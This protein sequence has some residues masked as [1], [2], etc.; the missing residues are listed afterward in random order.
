MRG[1]GGADACDLGYLVTVATDACVTQSAERQDWS[2]RNNRGYC[3][4][5]VSHLDSKYYQQR[6]CGGT[7]R[8]LRNVVTYCIRSHQ[9]RFRRLRIHIWDHAGIRCKQRF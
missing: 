4:L 3:D 8:Y 9:R 2:L 5:G 6:F 7:G 1:L